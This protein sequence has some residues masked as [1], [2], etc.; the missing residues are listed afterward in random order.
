MLTELGIVV[1]LYVLARLVSPRWRLAA[2]ATRIATAVAALV[3]LVDTG[4]T[5]ASGRSLFAPAPPEAT[6]EEVAETATEETSP[7]PS[8]HVNVTRDDGGSITT[9]LGY[10]IAVAKDSSLHREW[11]AVHDVRMPVQFQG[12]PGVTTVYV[13]QDYGGEYRYRARFEVD[14]KQPVRA[15]EIRFLTFDVWGNHVR[16]LNLGQVA[17]LPT[18]KTQLT[19]EWRLFDENDVESHYA[20]IAYVARAR[21]ADGKIVEMDTAP[22]VEEAQKFS[23]KF[24]AK[25]L[26]AEARRRGD[27]NGSDP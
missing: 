8:P 2:K 23:A 24:Q 15:L 20:S 26:D 6:P 16:S 25:D 22:V 27:Q 14:V 3:L 19:G 13:S 11:I 12:T 9:K 4:Y 5:V 1:A 10:G 21:L 18:G 17:D 7:A